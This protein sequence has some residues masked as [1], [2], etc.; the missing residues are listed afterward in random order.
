MEKINESFLESAKEGDLKAIKNA[1][2]KGAHI[3]ATDPD[4][5]TAMLLAVN[6][7]QG[8]EIVML[9]LEKGANSLVTDRAGKNLKD[10]LIMPE[11]PPK[12]HEN[13]CRKKKGWP[14]RLFADEFLRDEKEHS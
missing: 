3:D 13:A 5:K 14:I 2:E 4:G 1:L 12:E 6:E 7:K 9:L 11:E 8:C 10:H